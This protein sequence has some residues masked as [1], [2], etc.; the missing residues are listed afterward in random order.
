MV[1]ISTPLHRSGESGPDGSGPPGGTSFPAG[2][3]PARGLRLLVLGVRWPP[4]TFLERKFAALALRGL[5]VTVAARV[6]SSRA[7]CRIPGVRLLRLPHW[8]DRVADKLWGLLAASARLASGRGGAR[9][10]MRILEGSGLPLKR[11]LSRFALLERLASLRPDVVHFEW[12]SAAIEY[13]PYFNLWDCPKTVSCR[14]T[15]LHVAPYVPGAEAFQQALRA[16]LERADAVHCVSQALSN[17]AQ[18]WGAAPEKI[19]VIRPGVDAACFRPGP[20][21][22]RPGGAFRI[23]SVGSLRWMKGYEYALMALAGLRARGIR[24]VYEIA[25]DGPASERQRL[26]YVLHDLG[27]QDAVKL[28]GRLSTAGVRRLLQQADAFLLPSVSEGLSNAALEAMACGTPVVTTGCGGMPE[29]V[30]HGVE[31]LVTP[32]GDAP[33]MTAALERL[34]A[35]P[36]LRRR[37][38]EAA[39]ARVLREFTIE[40]HA[41]EFASFYRDVR[42]APETRVPLREDAGAARRRKTLSAHEGAFLPSQ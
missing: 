17:E 33:A 31:G 35:V 20:R 24:A 13:L 30:A 39:R 27:L 42:P 14:G 18:R 2:S 38:G 1:F 16:A 37:M 29:A 22:P 9:A 11:R 4:E 7:G 21:R 41:R 23:A 26:E 10:A 36:E 28:R 32:A 15:Q 34:W 12:N 3:A 6:P 19:R 40:R 25:G 5:R 8:E